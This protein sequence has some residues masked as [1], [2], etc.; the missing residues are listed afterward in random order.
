MIFLG[1]IMIRPITTVWTVESVPRLFCLGALQGRG[2][3]SYRL[4][5]AALYCTKP[6]ANKACTKMGNLDAL[7]SDSAPNYR[8]SGCAP[9]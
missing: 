9:S 6:R 1:I 3:P 8:I 2:A 5:G 7:Q 4:A